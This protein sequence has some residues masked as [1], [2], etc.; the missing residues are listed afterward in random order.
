MSHDFQPTVINTV[1]DKML[2]QT[3]ANA[4][5]P[6][7][8]VAMY[9]ESLGLLEAGRGHRDTAELEG[10][11]AGSQWVTSKDDTDVLNQALLDRKNEI[12]RLRLQLGNGEID[13][14]AVSRL[15]SYTNGQKEPLLTQFREDIE[16]PLVDRS[17]TRIS[18]ETVA[19]VA[20]YVTSKGG[21]S[22]RKTD[23]LQRTSFCASTT[24]KALSMLVDAGLVSVET[25]AEREG[26]G[27]PPSSYSPT[28]L[29]LDE[30]NIS[31]QLHIANALHQVADTLGCT[32]DE[33][34]AHV[35]RLGLAGISSASLEVE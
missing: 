7:I 10:F 8:S 13:N 32:Y 6:H 34:R 25:D 12:I 31:P 30:V 18:Q 29:L 28:D 17:K 11:D 4:M 27:R 26:L 5:D 33:A 22:V 9:S 20:G 14:A 1:H 15:P 35:I 19:I 21:D 23:F 24:T 3:M 16:L 2:A